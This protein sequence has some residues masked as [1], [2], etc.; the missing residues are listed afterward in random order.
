MTESR[1]LACSLD[2][3][4]NIRYD[5][6]FV[7]NSRHAEVGRERG[8]VIIGYL[9]LCRGEHGQKRGFTNVGKTDE[10]YVRYGF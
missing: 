8:K 10:T 9:R 5:E 3:S 6:I 2:K 4:R 1:S 7:E